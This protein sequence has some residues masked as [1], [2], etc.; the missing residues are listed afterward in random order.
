M[1]TLP[2][3]F[4]A[5]SQGTNAHC[6]LGLPLVPGTHRLSG[7]TAMVPLPAADPSLR[8]TA[9]ADRPGMPETAPDAA[10][11]QA[12]L[13]AGLRAGT[14]SRRLAKPATSSHAPVVR[15]LGRNS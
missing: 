3:T 11:I 15:R 10:S 6:R 4:T 2:E 14:G 7:G 9:R 1:E 5:I 8:N 12:R 13:P